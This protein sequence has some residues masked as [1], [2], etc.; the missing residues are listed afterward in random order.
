[1]LFL[2]YLTNS[3]DRV[4][5]ICELPIKHCTLR[6]LGGHFCDVENSEAFVYRQNRTRKQCSL[7]EN[8]NNNGRAQIIMANT[9][10]LKNIPHP[11]TGLV[12][13][14]SSRFRF[15]FS[16]RR[17]DRVILSSGVV[18]PR[19]GVQGLHPATRG[20]CFSLVPS[21]NPWSPFVNSQLVCLP[22][23]GIFNYVSF[24]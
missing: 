2:S 14:L 5:V 3:M 7:C 17:R 21:S 15:L 4:S 18:I 9:G 16:R 19:F 1:M 23:I 22:P 20:I 6:S 24:I 8:Q 12:Y 11:K 10:P 13:F